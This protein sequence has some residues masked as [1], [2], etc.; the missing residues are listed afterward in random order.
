MRKTEG[1]IEFDR[2]LER[3]DSNE[4]FPDLERRYTFEDM[5]S[6]EKENDAYSI[7][8]LIIGMCVVEA[9]NLILMLIF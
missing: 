1:H 6:L 4:G 2:E 9:I 3:L 8:V 7:K 5:R